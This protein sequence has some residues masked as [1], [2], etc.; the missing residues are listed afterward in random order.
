MRPNCPQIL[1]ENN[2]Q[3]S[4]GGLASSISNNAIAEFGGK[5]KRNSV[6]HNPQKISSGA[7]NARNYFLSAENV[8]PFGAV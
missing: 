8:L 1:R 6:S 4:R 5:R 2:R 7:K 3:L